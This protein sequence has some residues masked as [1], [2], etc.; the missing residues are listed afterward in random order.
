ML[1][2]LDRDG[3]INHNREDSVKT[4]DEF[5]LIDGAAEAIARLNAARRQ[6]AVV[7]NQSIIGRGI[8]D[9]HM[10]ERIHEKLTDALDRANARIDKF[11]ICPDAP[12]AATERRKPGAG[13]LRE[14]LAEFNAEPAATPFIGDA[15]RDLQA[16]AKAG[17]PR[18]LVRSG[19]GAKTQ[20]AGLP[21]EVLPVAVH[22]DLSAAVSALLED[23]S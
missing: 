21:A 9:K 4:P 2:L 20:A 1:V 17:C 11:Y 16:A 14:A 13:M 10:L 5:I 18:L 15:L 12:E 23:R 8:I 6:V 19:K 7:T 3:V 22:E